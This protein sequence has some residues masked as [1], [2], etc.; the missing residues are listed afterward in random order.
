[1]Y[2]GTYP[3]YHNISFVF[4]GLNFK[5]QLLGAAF[6]EYYPYMCVFMQDVVWHVCVHVQWRKSWGMYPH[7]THP[8]IGIQIYQL[9]NRSEIPEYS[10]IIPPPYAI[11]NTDLGHAACGWDKYVCMH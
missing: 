1:M 2:R 3:I 11:E 9:G 10:G 6:D 4:L 5:T 8:P 7:P